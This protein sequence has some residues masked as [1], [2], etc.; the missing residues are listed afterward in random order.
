[1]QKNKIIILA[2][3]TMLAAPIFAENEINVEND[4][5]PVQQTDVVKDEN[6]VNALDEDI[7]QAPEK[8]ISPYKQPTSK[9][10]TAQKFLMAML[11]VAAS[12]ALIYVLLTL[13]NKIRYTLS[14]PNKENSYEEP[15]LETPKTIEGAVRIFLDKTKW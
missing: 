1:M 9:K 4:V 14:V 6:A 5:N 12:S 2:L 11:G 13:Y 15:S 3:A 8:L 7:Q 10:Q